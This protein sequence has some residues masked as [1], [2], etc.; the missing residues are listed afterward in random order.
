MITSF[1][2]DYDLISTEP[3][4]KPE[5]IRTEEPIEKH[6]GTTILIES[7]RRK[8]NFDLAS[9][10]NGLRTRFHIFSSDFAV[11]INDEITIDTQEG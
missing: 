10:E 5:M 11:H 7:I 4:Y 6:S 3:N 8:A 1:K 2:M 9:I